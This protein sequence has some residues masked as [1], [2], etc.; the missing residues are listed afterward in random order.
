[1]RVAALVLAMALLAGCS[2][3]DGAPTPD[4]TASASGTAS[5]APSAQETNL[6]LTVPTWLPGQS[7]SWQ[8]RSPALPDGPVE[9]TTVVL[10]AD[11]GAYDIGIADAAQGTRAYPFHLVGLGPVDAACLCWLAHDQPVQLLRFPPKDG[12]EYTAD[13]W[14][15]PGATVTVVATNVSSPDGVAPGFQST[16][17]YSGGGTFLQ[18]EYVPRLG[19]FVRVASYFGDAEPF[20]EALLTGTGTGAQGVGFRATELAR[21]TASAT[22]P[23]S[24]APQALTIPT[25]ADL[26]LLACFIPGDQGFY[27]AE[28]AAAA[29]D[30]TPVACGGGSSGGTVLAAIA[31]PTQA[32]PATVSANT[33]GQG[34]I[35]VE[36]FAIDTDA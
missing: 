32:G 5:D 2:S 24:L 17:T 36:V 25:G 8:V 6:T 12:D 27:F 11:Q 26:A 18:A 7:W 19:Q 1:M 33:A 16:V 14:S 13:F 31:T 10:A 3:N 20:A 29:P 35:V 28:L 34:A 30:G 15:A 9:L 4:A 23:A 22:N 21:Y